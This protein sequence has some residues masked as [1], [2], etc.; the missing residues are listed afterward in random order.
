MNEFRQDPVSGDWVLIATG[1]ARKPHPRE[2]KLAQSIED[3]VFEPEKLLAQEK[4]V[5]IYNRGK[6]VNSLD[7]D[8]TTVVLPNKFPA[9]KSGV[10]GPIGNFG[11][12]AVAEGSGFHELVITRDHDRSFAQFTE[13]ETAEVLKIYRDRYLAIE[14]DD[15]GQ[16]ISIFHNHGFMAGASVYHNHSQI[17]SMPVI[18]SVA[19]QHLNGA[20]EYYKKTG[21]KVH[22]FILEWEFQEGKRIVYENDKFVVLCPYVSSAAYEMKIFPKKSNSYFS[23]ILDE[24]IPYFANAL[25]VAIKK[26]HLGLDGM[27][28]MFFIHTAPPKRDGT[29]VYDNYH[30]HLEIM[31]RSSIMAGQE[32]GTGVFVNT[33]DPDEAAEIFRKVNV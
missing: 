29:P 28:Y 1:R 15:C 20:E 27:D 5:A 24:D 17:I 22:E 32:F 18:S 31:P 13:E 9:V 33:V 25:S 19:L 21:K 16:S 11:P 26:L 10:C 14:K 3:C 12:F 2:E 4:P 8:W 6:L 30:W 23:T 7:E